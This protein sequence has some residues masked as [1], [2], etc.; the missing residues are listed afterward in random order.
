MQPVCIG[1]QSDRGGCSTRAN[2]RAAGVPV[3]QSRRVRASLSRAPEGAAS[4]GWTAP[5]TQE[6]RKWLGP[7]R[8]P[9]R[10]RPRRQ[11]PRRPSARQRS[12]RLAPGVRPSGQPAARRRVPQ[13][14]AAARRDRTAHA[15]LRAAGARL[16]SVSCQP[17]QS[18]E[19]PVP[20]SCNGTGGFFV[21]TRPQT[22]TSPRPKR[23]RLSGAELLRFRP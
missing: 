4:G 1:L 22:I 19:P 15:P 17:A 9:P 11:V 7:R 18:R 23:L 13:S 2:A 14:G 10:S 3:R 8:P 5:Y 20:F 21:C 6:P 16:L 12:A